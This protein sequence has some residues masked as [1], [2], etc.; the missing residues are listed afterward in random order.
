MIVTVDPILESLRERATTSGRFANIELV[1]DVLRCRARDIESEAWYLVE[2]SDDGV[3]VLLV[4]PDRWLSESIEADLMHSSDK[5]E[6]LL[7]EELVDLGGSVSPEKPIKVEHFRSDDRLYTFRSSIPSGS[8]QETI[9]R[10]L[11]AYEATFIELGD[12]SG[13]RDD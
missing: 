7:E 10:W 12:M 4:T 6:E 13:E 5:L 3:A 11:L 2:T 9:F 8:D 1:H